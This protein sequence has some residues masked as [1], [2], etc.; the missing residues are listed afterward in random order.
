MTCVRV[1]VRKTSVAHMAQEGEAET[2]G[3]F[4]YSNKITL[5]NEQTKPKRFPNTQDWP[6][7]T[8]GAKKKIKKIKIPQKPETKQRL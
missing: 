1:C 2:I 5:L 6:H 3:L 8:W 4:F 7:K